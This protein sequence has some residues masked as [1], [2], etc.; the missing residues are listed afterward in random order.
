VNIVVIEDDETIVDTIRLTFQVGWPDTRI[1]SADDGQKGLGLIESASPDAVILDIGLPDMSGF[2]VLEAIRLFSIVPVVILTVHGEE[3][4]VIKALE[5]GADD[6]VVKPF[7][8]LELLARIKA[9]IR[10]RHPDTMRIT[11][12]GPF[13]F[14]A[15]GRQ[16]FYQGKQINLTSTEYLLLRYLLLNKGVVVSYAQMAQQL[17][18]SPYPDCTKAIRVYISHL[19]KKIENEHGSNI[20][21]SHPGI[22][23][24]K[25][26]NYL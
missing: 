23:Y 4:D 22:G 7:R 13:Q 25:P 18:G 6:Y 17:W 21:T 10:T 16:V 1:L 2:E 12:I 11:S 14:N 20:I 19:R 5:L 9:A 15:S 26:K 3:R 8:Q 24:S